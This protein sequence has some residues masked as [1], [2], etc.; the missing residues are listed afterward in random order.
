M[1][2]RDTKSK[3]K[4]N[5]ML[6]LFL[7]CVSTFYYSL[8]F[9]R[10]VHSGV[11][12]YLVILCF[13]LFSSFLLLLLLSILWYLHVFCIRLNF[14]VFSYVHSYVYS[15][16]WTICH[17]SFSSKN[18][19]YLITNG[20]QCSK[21]NLNSIEGVSNSNTMAMQFKMYI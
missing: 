20:I 1:I 13:I 6:C 17:T 4:K 16:R 9:I 5:Y 18:V 3:K 8:F 15:I 2:L 10:F 21:S 14:L 7:I 19:S 11:S 12:I